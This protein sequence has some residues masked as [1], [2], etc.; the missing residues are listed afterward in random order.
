MYEIVLNFLSMEIGV[1]C[2]LVT[3]ALWRLNK[4]RTQTKNGARVKTQ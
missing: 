1:P 2:S 3:L 4:K